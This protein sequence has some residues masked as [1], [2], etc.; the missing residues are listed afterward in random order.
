MISEVT[1]SAVQCCLFGIRQG[2]LISYV[3]E[4]DI[5]PTERKIEKNDAYAQSLK[6]VKGATKR[7]RMVD[8][9][10]ADS[11]ESWL[12]YQGGTCRTAVSMMVHVPS[13]TSDLNFWSPPARLPYPQ[14]F[15][16]TSSSPSSLPNH[17]YAKDFERPNYF[18]A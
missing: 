1:Q 8:R 7:S 12:N 4:E 18:A 9:H 14:S 10:V 15:R 17:G 16:S 6:D 2:N 11:N 5:V 3:K 13:R